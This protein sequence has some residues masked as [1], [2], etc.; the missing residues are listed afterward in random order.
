MNR[1]IFTVVLVICLTMG[2]DSHAQQRSFVQEDVIKVA[3]VGDG[4]QVYTLNANQKTSV[5]TYADGL[6]RRLQTV[7]MAASPNQKDIIQPEVYNALGQQ[8]VAY[9]PYVAATGNGQFRSNA[10]AEQSTFYSTTGQKIAVDAKPYSQ[11]LFDN[12]PLQELLRSGSVGTGFQLNE[13]YKTHQTRS[14]T[15]GETVRRWHADGSAAGNYETGKLV[16]TSLTD[17]SG[18]QVMQ[19]TDSRGNTVM[20]KAFLNEGSTTWL[21]TYYVYS[22]AGLLLYVVPPKAVAIMNSANNYSLL[23][24]AV[25]Q[26]IFKYAYDHKGRLV[27]RTVPGS[28][29][30]YLVYDP[31]D[32]LVLAQDVKMRASHKW[33][34]IKYNSQGIAISQGIYTDN[35]RVGRTA[36][37]G[38]VAG[39]DYGS[40]YFEQ[41]NGASVTGFYSNV[42][43]PSANIEPL[44]Y[45]YFD[46]Y[47]LDGNGTADYAYQSQGLAGEESATS[48]TRGMAT[49]TSRR[50]IGNG[51]GNVWLRTVF[52]YDKRGN[53]IQTLSNNQLNA[54][55]NS[56]STIVPDFTGKTIRTKTTLVVPGTTTTVRTEL[57]YDHADRLLQ[58]DESHNGA[59]Y[60]RIGSYSYNELG[61]LVDKKLHSTNGGA[62]YLQSVDYRYTIAG[63]LK[64]INNATLTVDDNNDDSNDVF[65]MELLYNEYNGGLGNTSLYNGMVSA[66]RWKVNAPGVASASERSYIFQYDKLARLKNANY[67]DR[68]GTVLWYNQGA[69]D[70]KNI[71]YDENGNIINL[72]RSAV[73]GGSVAQVDN[74]VY[75]YTGNRLDNVADGTGGSYGLFGFKNLTG[76]TASYQY[77]TNGSL[78]VD[79]KK[80]LSLSY[81]LLGRTERITITTASGRYINYSYDAMGSL[82][83]KQAY[84]GGVLQKTT[85]YIGGFVFENGTLQHFP[86][87]EG[88]VRN[89]S[90][91]LKLEYVIADQQGNARVS[92][93]DQGGVAVVRQENSYYPFG[94]TMPGSVLPTAAN[95]NLYNGGSEWQ[96]D[97]AD[98]PD[99]QQTFYRMY[100]PAL[101]RFIAVDPMA[102][103]SDSDGPYHYALNNPIMFNDP[104]GD[105]AQG[106]TMASYGWSSYR[107]GSG[108]GNH[109]S[110][111]NYGFLPN[112][113]FWNKVYD[114]T[115]APY[116]GYW[117]PNVGFHKF[118]TQGAA[119]GHYEAIHGDRPGDSYLKYLLSNNEK[120]AQ[121]Y[122]MVA[123]SA[124]N[125]KNK[126]DN[127]P[128]AKTLPFAL[129][130]S[131]SD[132]P[133]P[134]GE[135]VGAAALAIAAIN[136]PAI[137]A[138]MTREIDRIKMKTV[139]PN[140]FSYKLTV[141]LSGDYVNVRGNVV[142][143]KKGD[144]WKYGETT[145]GIDRYGKYE[146]NNMIPGGVS[147]MPIHYGNQVDIKINEKSLIYGYFLTHGALPPGNKIFR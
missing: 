102:E 77:D 142:T 144:V 109:W 17:E 7:A 26:L 71:N 87:A 98:L 103:A 116:G 120:G 58:I 96:D 47:D 12:S 122:A 49:I 146:L 80:G 67:A 4:A 40:N 42:S 85:D 101:G 141:N 72:Q 50:T 43:F 29:V 16:V 81:N 69:F 19:Y 62:S 132:G 107:T 68:N 38:Y 21:E 32:R 11:Q 28:A 139:G 57:A 48:A 118:Q 25:S 65:G 8:T 41:R 92:F 52:F 147:M 113:S 54:S 89:N 44:A 76:S 131:A 3:G 130:T 70:E 13:N 5:R 61:Q 31:L 24:P 75:S 56:V 123:V 51:L 117:N 126:K 15:S 112:E 128:L 134:I 94:L 91:S 114:M 2:F 64:S 9:L 35:S 93:E 135:A 105:V 90:G 60:V 136:T 14:S 45:S 108:S 39:L 53:L 97:F 124:Q 63:Q 127:S 46:D 59:A 33:N 133:L 115:D 88:R 138:K 79:P 27:E 129:T 119:D 83:R 10:L 23:Q 125:S 137:V 74:L 66:V 1:Y 55:M 82:L 121:I 30:A 22:D 86:M 143:L 106:A 100:D 6:G 95:K 36:M 104:L 73:I 99:L 111:K 110:D 78:E 20:K 37:Q 84:D 145:Q 140:G 34:Y 18:G